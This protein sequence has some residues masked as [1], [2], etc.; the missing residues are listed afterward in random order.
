MSW[1]YEENLQSETQFFD[2]HQV[3]GTRDYSAFLTIPKA[4]EFMEQNNWKEVSKNCRALVQANAERFCK[5]LNA[6]ALAPIS[7]EFLV[8]LYSIPIKTNKPEQLKKELFE[9]YKIEIPVMHLEDKIFL[10][11]SIQAFNSQEDLDKLFNALVEIQAKTNL[12][13]D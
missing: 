12:I 7:D 5:L 4:I 6:Q 9:K 1:G 13:E 2:Y 10:R 3:Q 8:Q 11:Y